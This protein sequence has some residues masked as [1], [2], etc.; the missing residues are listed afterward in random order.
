MRRNGFTRSRGSLAKT[1]SFDVAES[2]GNADL[3]TSP[4]LTEFP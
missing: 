3:T 1:L 2:A 4:R